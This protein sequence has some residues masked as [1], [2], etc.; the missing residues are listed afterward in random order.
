MS[1]F[2][3][4]LEALEFELPQTRYPLELTV[5]VAGT[6]VDGV[7]GTIV[8]HISIISDK[9]IWVHETDPTV[10]AT[11][12]AGGRIYVAAN[13]RR[14][15]AWNSNAVSVVNAVAA[16]NPKVYVEGWV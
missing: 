6:K 8:N 9:A 2:R 5:A 14:V 13:E 11:G 12:V 7:F 15:V 10:A 3:S 4:E 1:G 16:E